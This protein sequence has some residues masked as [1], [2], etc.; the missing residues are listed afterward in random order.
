[1]LP[2]ID[3]ALLYSAHAIRRGQGILVTEKPMATEGERLARLEGGYNKSSIA[4]YVLVD[5]SRIQTTCNV[6]EPPF[7]NRQFTSVF[8]NP[9]AMKQVRETVDGGSDN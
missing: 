8:T 2:G 1:M 7:V 3:N 5:R 9:L 4:T 6:G